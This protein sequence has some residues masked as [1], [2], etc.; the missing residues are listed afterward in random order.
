M[1]RLR[2]VLEN[3]CA[4]WSSEHH[5]VPAQGFLGDAARRDGLRTA[6]REDPENARARCDLARAVADDGD[7]EAAAA[8]LGD[9]GDPSCLE[10]RQH[11]W[12]TR[13]AGPST[14]TLF[15]WS[16]TPPGSP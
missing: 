6:L 3:R 9:K 11:V 14:P 13:P 5:R 16:A 8:V 12:G 10:S 4:A 15:A 2:A 1:R 7:P